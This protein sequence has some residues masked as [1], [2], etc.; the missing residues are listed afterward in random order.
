MAIQ[1]TQKLNMATGTKPTLTAPALSEDFPCGPGCF[2][3]VNIGATATVV[4]VVDPRS[5]DTGIAAPDV[6]IGSATSV[7][8]WIPLPSYLAGSNGYATLSFSQV[9]AV[10]V[11][12]VNVL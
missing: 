2:A 1:T 9:A 8:K 6:A 7:E 12:A 10:T 5:L 4:T 11:A 3:I